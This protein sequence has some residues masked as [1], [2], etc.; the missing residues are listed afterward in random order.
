M[1]SPLRLCATIHV[2]TCDYATVHHTT[3]HRRPRLTRYIH[4][5]PSNYALARSSSWQQQ[6]FVELVDADRPGT[7]YISVQEEE[8]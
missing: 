3:N 1:S 2:L 4:D 7:S 5:P 6:R 8:V